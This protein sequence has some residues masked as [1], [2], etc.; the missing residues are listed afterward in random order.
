MS[1]QLT[2]CT[3]MDGVLANIEPD[4]E[5]RIVERFGA[6]KKFPNSF[7]MDRRYDVP[8][9]EMDD[10]VH[11]EVFSDPDFWLNAEPFQS[12]IDRLN[13]WYDG[14]DTKRIYIVTGRHGEQCREATELWLDKYGIKHDAVF[15]DTKD[16][17]AEVMKYVGADFII[18]DR[19]EEVWSVAKRKRKAYLLEKHYNLEHKDKLVQGRYLDNIIWV[20]SF[21]DIE[22]KEGI[23]A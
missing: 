8:K 1:L 20:K 5:K 23:R 16:I 9:K 10:F 22:L 13:K 7:Y 14:Y 21:L 11:N 3:D 15:T 18:E 2:V 19:H 4:L 12:N 6:E 17:K